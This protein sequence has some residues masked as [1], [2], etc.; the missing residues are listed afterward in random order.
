MIHV[1]EKPERV[2]IPDYA[3]L[4]PTP[5]QRF[6]TRGVYDDEHTHLSFTQGGGHGGSHPHLANA[7]LS[8]IRSDRPAFPDAAT[9]ANWTMVGICAHESAMGGGQRV[10]IPT[11]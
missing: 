7:F 9:S 4:L 3:H 2:T 11:L 10:K 5:I 8:A 1:G 6:T